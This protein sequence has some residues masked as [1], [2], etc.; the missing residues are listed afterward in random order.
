MFAVDHFHLHGRPGGLSERFGAFQTVTYGPFSALSTTGLLLAAANRHTARYTVPE[1]KDGVGWSGLQSP[2]VSNKYRAVHC[3]LQACGM[4]TR[5][6]QSAPAFLTGQAHNVLTF[7]AEVL[8]GLHMI[9]LDIL[10]LTLIL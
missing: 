7:H 4:I 2:G 10:C 1:S 3:S 5:S 8:H 9:Y 6:V